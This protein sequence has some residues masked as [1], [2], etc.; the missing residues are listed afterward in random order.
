MNKMKK[1]KILRKMKAEGA[2]HDPE[3]EVPDR[4]EIPSIVDRVDE[5][6]G[7]RGNRNLGRP[8]QIIQLVALEETLVGAAIGDEEQQRHGEE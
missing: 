6:L 2:A 3:I 5:I 7:E 1:R 4:P 8:T